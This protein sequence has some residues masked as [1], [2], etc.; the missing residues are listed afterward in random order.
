MIILQIMRSNKN[1]IIKINSDYILSKIGKTDKKNVLYVGP[2][3]GAYLNH[4]KIDINNFYLVEKNLLNFN[5]FKILHPHHKIYNHDIL[6]PKQ[7]FK[8]FFD[9][10][11]SFS[12][13]QYFSYQELLKYNEIIKTNLKNKDSYCINMSIPNIEMRNSYILNAIF[14]NNYNL[15]G[16]L[17]DV[18][19]IIFKNNALF[20]TDVSYW[21]NPKKL[22]NCDVC[23]NSD[24]FYRFDYSL[25]KS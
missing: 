11:F 22:K 9:I 24:V 4:L 19:G 3:D 23:Y 20:S 17:F 2:G 16:F 8:N 1:N 5:S 6:E 7:K 18:G 12:L 13:V 14:N 10:I 21:H 25:R 15:K